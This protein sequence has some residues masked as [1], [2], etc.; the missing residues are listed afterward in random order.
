MGGWGVS[1]VEPIEKSDRHSSST[2][3]HTITLP[4]PPTPAEVRL[5]A[6]VQSGTNKKVDPIRVPYTANTYLAPF[7]HTTQRLE[8]N[9]RGHFDR[10][11]RSSPQL[12]SGRSL[13]PHD[14]LNMWSLIC[15]PSVWC[16]WDGLIR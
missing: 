2:S 10:L 14:V 7:S 12:R 13:I 16:T 9:G 11:T 8:D 3:I 4:I 15:N 5:A 1:R 6:E